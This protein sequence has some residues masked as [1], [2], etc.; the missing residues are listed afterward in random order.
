MLIQTCGLDTIQ[1]GQISVKDDLHIPYRQNP[2]LERELRKVVANCD[3]LR[4]IGVRSDT[5]CLLCHST[6]FYA[7]VI[8][9]LQQPI[10][11][12]HRGGLD[13]VYDVNVRFHG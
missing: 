13:V 8:I 1:F 10:E 7:K 5:T 6:F 9:F 11:F 4:N 12:S 3:H 2:A